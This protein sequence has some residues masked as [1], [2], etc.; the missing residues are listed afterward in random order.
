MNEQDV[1]ED[2]VPK[3][4]TK[5]DIVN[6]DI[7]KVSMQKFTYSD[8]NPLKYNKNR[9]IDFD[10]SNESENITFKLS[11]GEELFVTK[12]WL[13]EVAF[14]AF[15]EDFMP[16]DEI[17]QRKIIQKKLFKVR[18]N[19]TLNV[20]AVAKAY[21]NLLM[22]RKKYRQ[23]IELETDS[24]IIDKYKTILNILKDDTPIIGAFRLLTRMSYMEEGSLKTELVE[25]EKQR[26][27]ERKKQEEIEYDE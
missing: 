17:D 22:E 27:L 4:K 8:D 2:V 15:P 13:K 9:I 12:K 20:D 23:K 10:V 7:A 11:N 16:E 1:N 18:M 6:E 19:R 26:I 24:K 14:N 21:L 25:L 5:P 3:I